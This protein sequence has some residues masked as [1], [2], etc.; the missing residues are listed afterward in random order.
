MA[1][2]S[3]PKPSGIEA[4]RPSVEDLERFAAAIR[5]SWELEEPP[6]SLTSRTL[7]V[8][9]W[10]AIRGAAP[11]VRAVPD[12]PSAPALPPPAPSGA[13]PPA[14][15][16]P[17]EVGATSVP[18]IASVPAQSAAPPEASVASPSFPPPPRVPTIEGSSPS[19]APPRLANPSLTSLSDAF[20]AQKS[21]KGLYVGLV[22]A[23]GI[24]AAGVFAF[25]A[26]PDD[27]TADDPKTTT[28]PPGTLATEP[29][30]PSGREDDIPA[31]PP[32]A[33]PQ[34]RETTEPL[35]AASPTTTTK[36]TRA[37]NA[38]STRH[39]PAQNA[40]VSGSQAALR[41]PVATPKAP[42]RATTAAPAPKPSNKSGSGG[43]VRDVPF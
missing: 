17:P 11:S 12:P 19:L 14:S 1:S 27:A 38:A 2:P 3:A 16:P 9:D 32:P 5:P 31:P 36:P 23:A 21:K 4:A 15:L 30:A 35:R 22:I 29:R 42:P 8:S 26:S 7:S 33:A 37:T 41:P 18:P 39:T 20:P 24:A 25:S 13:L 40:H 34:P 43:I 10:E 6:F 28:A